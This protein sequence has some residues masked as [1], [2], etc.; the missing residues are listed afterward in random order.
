[1]VVVTNYSEGLSRPR[2]GSP[3][4]EVRRF[5]NIKDIQKGNE[6]S[7]SSTSPDVV[8]NGNII[9][10]QEQNAKGNGPIIEVWINC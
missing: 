9:E 2:V 3:W 10:S 8:Y 7:G 1:M 4:E 5:K 6:G